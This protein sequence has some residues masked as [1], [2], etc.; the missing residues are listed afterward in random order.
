MKMHTGC[1]VWG[2][3]LKDFS[4]LRHV[5][6]TQEGWNVLLPLTFAWF[7]PQQFKSFLSE[8][9]RAQPPLIIPPVQSYITPQ[10]TR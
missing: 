7:K 10:V 3:V 8:R 9:I 2:G 6:N 5:E 4:I 1:G